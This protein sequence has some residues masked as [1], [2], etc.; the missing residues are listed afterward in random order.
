MI[1]PSST[2]IPSSKHYSKDLSIILSYQEEIWITL[3]L[4]LDSLTFITR[5]QNEA[6]LSPE[7]HNFIVVA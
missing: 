1:N 6:R 5:P 2:P 4:Q 3:Q 7:F